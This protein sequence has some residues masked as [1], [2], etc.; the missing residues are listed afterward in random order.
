MPLLLGLWAWR[1][2]MR[3][4]PGLDGLLL[5]LLSITLAWATN[6][7]LQVVFACVAFWV[8]QSMG[9]WGVWSGRGR[10]SRATSSRS[11]SSPAGSAGSWPGCPSCATLAIP[12]EVLTGAAGGLDALRADRAPGRLAGG[13]HCA[14]HHPVA[15]RREALRGLRRVTHL[16][17][18]TAAYARVALMVAVHSPMMFL[19]EALLAFAWVAWTILPLLVVFQYADGIQGW[20]RDEAFLVVG[21]FTISNT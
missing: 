18:A 5:G 7:A 17:R 16:G 10:S 11:S 6:V 15:A 8:E 3:V 19:A 1:P 9:L 14:R 13:V 20:T 4:D 21:F 2:D 12:V